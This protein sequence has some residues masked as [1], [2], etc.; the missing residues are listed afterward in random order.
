MGKYLLDPLDQTFEAVLL[1][2]LL[3][4]PWLTAKMVGLTGTYL[5]FNW[6][7]SGVYWAL[8]IGHLYFIATKGSTAQSLKNIHL[9]QPHNLKIK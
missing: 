1:R 6:G 4:G 5:H 9:V 7:S 2:E 3:L 8:C